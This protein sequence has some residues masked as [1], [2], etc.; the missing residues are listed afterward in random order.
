MTTARTTSSA[1]TQRLRGPF[2][3]DQAAFHGAGVRPP[4]A[5]RAGT[6]SSARMVLVGPGC[7]VRA[8]LTVRPGAVPRTWTP[9]TVRVRFRG[10][11]DLRPATALRVVRVRR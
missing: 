5:G 9:L 11:P 7:R 3:V 6:F 10:S 1:V 8:V 2:T 4:S